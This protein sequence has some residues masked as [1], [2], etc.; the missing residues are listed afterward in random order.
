MKKKNIYDMNKD[1]LEDLIYD[2]DLDIDTW[3]DVINKMKTYDFDEFDYDAAYNYLNEEIEEVTD[4]KCL[5]NIYNKMKKY[6]LNTSFIKRLI[7]KIEEENKPL[8]NNKLLVKGAISSVLFNSNN[9]VLESINDDYEPFQYEE[10]EL[11]ED[12]YYYEDDKY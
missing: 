7:N 12:D 1:E 4:I 3:I 6:K 5:K 9:Q 8:I 10:E 2:E 11:E